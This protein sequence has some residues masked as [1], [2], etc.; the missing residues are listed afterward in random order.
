[1][2]RF[3]QGVSSDGVA[4]G[5]SRPR[6]VAGQRGGF[7]GVQPMGA[8]QLI[9]CHNPLGPEIRSLFC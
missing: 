2:G 7:S 6:T 8:S 4:G 3:P 9:A 5:S 1:M